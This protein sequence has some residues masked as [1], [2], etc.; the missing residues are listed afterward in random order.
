MT[1]PGKEPITDPTPPADPPK[2]PPQDPPADP[3][4][5]PKPEDPPAED[6]PPSD[7]PPEGVPEAYDFKL[8]D[9]VVM[10][11]AVRTSVTE[12][13][14]ELELPQS[15]VDKLMPLFFE[16]VQTLQ[17]ASVQAYV[18]QVVQWGKDAEADKEFGG[19]K[20]QE[21]MG[22]VA[23][24]IDRWGTPELKQFCEESGI[25][26]HPEFLRMLH[27]IYR[28]VGA[29]DSFGHRREPQG[30]EGKTEADRARRLYPSMA[31]QK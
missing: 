25:G 6:P 1:E 16:Q 18:N 13:F 19:A 3:P 28:D 14:K 24:V 27:R 23:K 22:G 29:E 4:A 11:D 12:V 21:N 2:D 26:N 20:F 30:T 8:P 5:D 7:P 15:K 9:G 17:E 10:E 31:E